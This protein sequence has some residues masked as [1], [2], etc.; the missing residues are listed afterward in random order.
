MSE[1]GSGTVELALLLPMLLLVILALAEVGSIARVQLQ[2]MA[3]SREGARVAATTP[4]TVAA[5]EAARNAL[6]EAVRG[7]AAVTVTRPGVVGSPAVVE[8]V[9]SHKV[10]AVVAGGVDVTLAASSTMRVE[11]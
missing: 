5:I 1:R 10:A 9:V 11:Q 3:A 6:P 4:N 7:R 2:V 8:V